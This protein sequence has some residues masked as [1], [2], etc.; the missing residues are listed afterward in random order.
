MQEQDFL[1]TLYHI[2]SGTNS[3]KIVNELISQLLFAS[4]CFSVNVLFILLIYIILLFLRR[5]NYY[6]F[7]NN[8]YIS[9]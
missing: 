1:D 8:F 5:L 3:S 7:L 2:L 6:I 9:L 4:H